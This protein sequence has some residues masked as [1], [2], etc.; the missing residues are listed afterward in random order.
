MPEAVQFNRFYNFNTDRYASIPQ[1]NATGF[2]NS[3]EIKQREDF[4]RLNNEISK[5]GEIA[6]SVL[7]TGDVIDSRHN[8]FFGN[9]EQ[10]ILEVLLTRGE[11]S[12][13][14]EL[15]NLKDKFNVIRKPAKRVSKEQPKQSYNPDECVPV[16]ET[17]DVYQELMVRSFDLD[18]V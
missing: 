18:Y 6:C 10:K 1:I 3:I 13:V 16:R 11:L 14:G 4:T 8:T 17:G 15:A 7:Q 2:S 12:L 5:L 9:I